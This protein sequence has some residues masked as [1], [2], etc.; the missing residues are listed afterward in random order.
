MATND[1]LS[2]LQQRIRNYKPLITHNISSNDSR[3]NNATTNTENNEESMIRSLCD[4]AIRLCNFGNYTGAQHVLNDA[5]YGP[6]KEACY[7][8]SLYWILQSEISEELGN[9]QDCDIRVAFASFRQR[10][11]ARN[12]TK[13]FRQFDEKFN[14]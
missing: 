8:Y 10:H 4:V 14:N 2:P 1:H 7:K 9:I 13:K 5:L 11:K 6:Q 12:P 3:I